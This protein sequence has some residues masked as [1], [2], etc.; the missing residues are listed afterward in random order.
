[1]KQKTLFC[2]LCVILL[3][4]CGCGGGKTALLRED[5][6][7]EQQAEYDRFYKIDDL[8]A[9]PFQDFDAKVKWIAGIYDEEQ[10]IL[11]VQISVEL[12]PKWQGKFKMPMME[13]L[14][15]ANLRGSI[16]TYGGGEPWFSDAYT[17]HA[18]KV[19]MDELT[20][21]NEP[22][23]VGTV[24]IFSFLQVKEQGYAPMELMEQLRDVFVYLHHGGK[25]NEQAALRYE[26]EL[27]YKEGTFDAA[28]VESFVKQLPEMID[29]WS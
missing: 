21:L 25:E 19:S 3:L 10:D 16:S 18:D 23:A 28:S 7:A 13:I 14:A 17:I 8:I 2:L 5:L 6:T 22:T 27:Y 26:G 20:E 1:M 9:D 4:L 11:A 29:D 24:G 12:Y 15:P